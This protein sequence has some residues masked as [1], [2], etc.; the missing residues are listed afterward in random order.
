MNRYS[1]RVS[2]L[3]VLAVFLLGSLFLLNPFGET[4]DAKQNSKVSKSSSLPNDLKPAVAKSIARDDSSYHINSNKD[5]HTANTPTQG[6]E[7][8]FGKDGVT[9]KSGSD[10][11]ELRLES[12]GRGNQL[13]E[14][15]EVSEAISQDNKLELTRGN[16]TEWYV[17]S[18][19]G[20]EQ[21]FTLS[22]RP[23]GG[24]GK[25]NILL[26][27]NTK[28]DLQAKNSENG[29]SIKFTDS[30]DQTVMTYSKL[31][32]YDAQGKE[33]ESS[34]KLLEEGIVIAYNDTGAKYPVVVDPLVEVQRILASNGN[35]NDE[36]GACSAV[37]DTLA[38]VGAPEKGR[39]F[40]YIFERDMAGMWN[41]VRVIR[42][43]DDGASTGAEFGAACD[44][45]GTEDFGAGVTAFA[46][47]GAPEDDH[48]AGSDHGS[49]F[50]YERD[51]AGTWTFVEEL[52]AS[53][54]QTEADFGFDVAITQEGYIVVGA[55]DEDFGDNCNIFGFDNSDKGA[56]YIYERN[57]S[58]PATETQRIQSLVPFCDD[59]FGEGVGIDGPFIMVG[60]PGTTKIIIESPFLL[61]DAGAVY[62]FER[63]LLFP[64][65]WTQ[66]GT[67][68]IP[69][70]VGADDEFGD[71]VDVYTGDSGT[72]AIVGAPEA[73]FDGNEGAGEAYILERGDT[74]PN[75]LLGSIQL[76]RAPMEFQGEEFEFGS[77]VGIWGDYAIVGAEDE[78]IDGDNAVGASYIF[79]LDAGIWEFEQ[80]LLASDM[81]EDDKFGTSCDIDDLML[82]MVYSPVAI[83]GAEDNDI[84]G[85]NDQ[86]A[87]YLFEQ[88]QGEI[89]IAKQ[90]IPDGSL[91]DFEFEG[92]GF[93]PGNECESFMLSDDSE[94]E[95][96]EQTP[97]TFTINEIG[98]NGSAV[99]IECD[100]G[101]WEQVDNGVV[102]ELAGGDDITCTFTNT[103]PLELTPLFPSIRNLVNMMTATEA[104]PSGKVAFAWGFSLG[105]TIVGG[106]ICNGLELGINPIQLLGTEFADGNGTAEFVF[107]VPTLSGI[108]PV[109][110]QAIDIDTCRASEVVESILTNQ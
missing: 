86:G 45:A 53:S 99:S 105:T 76:L 31:Y 23:D 84:D 4:L 90:T 94:Q 104:T 109:Y 6:L 41:E 50:V 72:R 57:G 5:V 28:G 9:F 14:V 19:L 97:G 51:G 102:I 71:H 29:K 34:M 106:S 16:V 107:F 93:E 95:C 81:G 13:I 68:I 91:F 15:A 27:L 98:T 56:A 10:S 110:A 11:F 87:A 108:N 20:V 7:T 66:N 42:G 8:E 67:R 1:L 64:D 26:D 70:Q 36:F 58:W 103:I 80:R 2:A 35:Q 33:L 48:G 17:N 78:D 49:A 61:L 22:Q 52:R 30:S 89:T 88:A 46:V 38:V 100:S 39:G 69:S 83:V 60:A 63:D 43:Q 24:E 77:C 55:P 3:S 37:Y 75:W 40:A 74:F 18:L 82:S 47:I 25:V 54:P 59:N 32:V 92:I 62:P 44:I 79:G 96:G 101:D 12:I 73:S 85:E 65:V 21:G